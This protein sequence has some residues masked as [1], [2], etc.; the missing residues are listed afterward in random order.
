MNIHTTIKLLDALFPMQS[1]SYKGKQTIN[2]SHNFLLYQEVSLTIL[3]MFQF[4]FKMDK[5]TDTLN[6]DLQTILGAS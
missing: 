3:G 4:R 1:V 5:K 2:S 6:E